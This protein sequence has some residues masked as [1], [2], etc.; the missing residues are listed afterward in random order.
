[1]NVFLIGTSNTGKTPI[2]LKFIELGYQHIKAS[3]YFRN[4]FVSEIS[5]RNEFTKAISEFSMTE[6]KKNYLVNVDYI[7]PKL[8]IPS[9]IE[10][11]RNPIDF[12]GLFKPGDKVIYLENLH[13]SIEKTVFEKGLDVIESYLKWM[14]EIGLVEE[15]DFIKISFSSFFG[16]GSLEEQ[17]EEVL[18]VC[19][20]RD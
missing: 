11:V 12:C 14:I 2:A 10:G 5:D 17:I 4:S 3:E 6:L 20:L 16:K 18:N 13:N 8:N 7:Q 9:V 15:N 1:M 19:S